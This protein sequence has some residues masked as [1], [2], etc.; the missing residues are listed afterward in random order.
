MVGYRQRQAR[1]SDQ[2]A[3]ASGASS[4][5]ALASY[6]VE[7][8]SW[9]HMSAPQIQKIASLAEADGV[10]KDDIKVL[11][12]LGTHGRHPK[13]CHPELL[14]RLNPQALL[15]AIAQVELPMKSPRAGWVRVQQDFVLPHQFFAALFESHPKAF[16][17]RLCG[18]PGKM[19]EFWASALNHPM[20]ANHPLANR[21]GFRTKGIP[22]SLHGDGVPVAGIGKAHDARQTLSTQ[23]SCECR[24]RLMVLVLRRRWWSWR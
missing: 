11:S 20:L 18:P 14:R 16:R 10:A 7:Q 4:S 13:N 24:S 3:S 5:S 17:E 8:W 23:C 1:S 2:G 12:A 6:L 21:V 9:G 22:I 15:G 19:Q